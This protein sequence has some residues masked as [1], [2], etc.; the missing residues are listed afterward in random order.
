MGA[1]QDTFT[2]WITK[3]KRA[4]ETSSLSKNIKIIPTPPTLDNLEEEEI[5]D[6]RREYIRMTSNWILPSW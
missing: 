6:E 1:F 4:K 5:K 3:V 2:W